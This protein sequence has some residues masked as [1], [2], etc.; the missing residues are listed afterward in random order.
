VRLMR[1]FYC[2]AVRVGTLR[3]I[4]ADRFERTQSPLQHG[5]SARNTCIAHSRP[6][7]NGLCSDLSAAVR[8]P[9]ETL[10]GALNM[11]HVA[12]SVPAPHSVP[13]RTLS[14]T[15]ACSWLPNTSILNFFSTKRIVS[16]SP[17]S[18][19]CIT[20]AN[21]LSFILLAQNRRV[22]LGRNQGL[23]HFRV[24]LSGGGMN[25]IVGIPGGPGLKKFVKI[26]SIKTI[27]K[28][29]DLVSIPVINDNIYFQHQY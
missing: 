29:I 18:H 22:F 11:G 10:P 19:D 9:L 8:C 6:S 7:R 5:T 26:I 4:P 14:C 15:A 1:G 16:Q 17:A 27:T 28:L 25:L 24:V 20:L 12:V 3:H 23:R 13:S 2:A 21:T